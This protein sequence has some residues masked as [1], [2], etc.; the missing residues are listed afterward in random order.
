MRLQG[1]VA[2]VTGA[3]T[4]IGRACVEL[5]AREGATVV[6]AEIDE[7]S[8]HSA[9]E[10]LTRQGHRGLFV[11]TDV[12]EPESVKRVVDTAMEQFGRIDV[13]YNNAGGLH[14]AG[15]SGHQPIV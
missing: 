2:L 8:G 15:R 10:D 1:K 13:L 11:P 4:G 9:Q 6:I 7:A 12:S 3:G 14:A 5:F